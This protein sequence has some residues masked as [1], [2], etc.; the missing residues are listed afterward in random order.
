MTKKQK[1]ILRLSVVFNLVFVLGLFLNWFNSPSYKLGELKQDIEL[2]LFNKNDTVLFK[3][4]K[5]LTVR[6]VSQRGLNA[7]GQFENNRFEI[8]VTSEKDLV[9]YNAA[10][11]KLLPFGNFYSADT[12]MAAK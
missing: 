4:P 1:W 6:N 2:G 5:G 9:N 11:E 10:E 3:L 7:I 12:D 8:V